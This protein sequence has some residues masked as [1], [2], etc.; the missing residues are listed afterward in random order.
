M[1]NSTPKISIVT[2]AYNMERFIE[3]TIR[4]VVDQKTPEVEYVL[5]DGA[6]SDATLSIA[7]RY[8][9]SIDTLISEP[10][11]GQYHAIAKG[12]SRCSGEIMGWINADDILMP[13]TFSVVAQIF[14]QFPEVDWITGSPSFLNEAGQLGRIQWRLPA[15]PRSFIANGWYQR[16][17]GAYLQQE[18][19][20]WRRSLWDRVGGLDLRHGLAADF[21]LWT[22]FAEHADLIPVDLPLAA[23]RER[24]DARSSA[25]AATYEAEVAAICAAKPRPPALWRFMAGLGLGPRAVARLLIR[26]PG[27]AIIYDRNRR[28]WVKVRRWRS[29]SRV[30]PSMLLDEWIMRRHGRTG[31]PAPSDPGPR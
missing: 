22:R 26:R 11:D 14:D 28:A 3:Q 25:G 13:W 9:A 31:P 12:F 30:S 29:I 2:A 10:D 27:G 5:V 7:R 19:M 1:T 15:Y 8:A 6:S 4:S 18:S 16:R 23:F 21:D 24:A 17:L 20:F